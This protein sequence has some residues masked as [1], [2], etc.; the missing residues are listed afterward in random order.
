MITKRIFDLFFASFGLIVLA[1]LFFFLAIWIK[2]DSRGT[3]YFRQE[4]V[5]QYGKIFRIH[6]FRT[7]VFEPKDTGLQITVRGD[8]RI[9]RSGR[10]LRKYK[11][12]E[13]PQ[14]LDVIMGD[15]SLVGPRPEVPAYVAKYPE[16]MK[17]LVLSVKPGITDFASIEFRDEAHILAESPDPEEAYVNQI[18]PVKL[19]YYR[20]YVAERSLWLDSVLIF[21]TLKAIFWARP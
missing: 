19:N 17:G 21:R 18:L 7:M 2:L 10:F 16:E 1:P 3:V 15:M 14:I 12:D 8:P 5:G 9:T 4:R 6:K 13:L 20:R 11:L